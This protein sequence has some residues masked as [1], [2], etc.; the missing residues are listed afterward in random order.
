MLTSGLIYLKHSEG[1]ISIL[2][3]MA[4]KTIGAKG[5]NGD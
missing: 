1:L 5:S 3:D 4:F 2:P